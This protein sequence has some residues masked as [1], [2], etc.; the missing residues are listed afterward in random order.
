MITFFAPDVVSTASTEDHKYLETQVQ[1]MPSEMACPLEDASANQECWDF[2]DVGFRSEAT[3]LANDIDIATRSRL[4]QE[5]AQGRKLLEAKQILTRR[6][7]F[8]GFRE[9]LLINLAEG[10]KVMKIF[11]QF[12]N[13]SLD[14]L[15]IISSAVN[16][17]TL[18]QSKFA[19]VVQQLWEA[20]DITKEFVKN[21]VK[22]VRDA[23]RVERRKKQQT[24]SGSG[25]RHDLSGGG[26]HYQL[27]PMYNEKAA[28]KIEALAEER[29][30]RAIVIV[31][32]AIA[33]FGSP[34]QATANPKGEQT[35]V[36][37]LRREHQEL[38]AVVSEVRTE[39]IEMQRK[40]IE[41]DARIAELEQRGVT[42]GS[43]P[44]QTRLLV[45]VSA[46]EP[47]EHN[48]SSWTEFVDTV[49]CDASGAGLPASQARTL[50]LKTVK[51]WLLQERQ[52]LC[53]LLAEYLG[54]EQDALD[55]VAWVPEK[56]LS[57]AL[58]K[59]SFYVSQISG[60][61]NMFDERQWT[62]ISSETYKKLG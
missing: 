12:G 56:L 35:A 33:S 10:R 30:V 16:L 22:E 29:G 39:H 32:E 48:F 31:E 34:S 1:T 59:L 61:D 2:I 51:T 49:Q 50:L 13:W 3:Q 15:L 21:L 9:K 14:K 7:E 55:Q 27:P 44:R 52:A 25:W 36:D 42:G 58:S 43:F 40:T 8:S 41:R 11:K 57:S 24:D 4:E 47:V 38:Q 17:Y 46:P 5:L 60:P 45:P 28:M 37:E 20:T 62:P 26:R 23:A 19:T 53:T 54:E 18:C 6:G